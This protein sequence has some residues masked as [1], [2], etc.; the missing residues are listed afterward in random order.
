MTAQQ[1]G[2][3]ALIPSMLLLF[4]IFSDINTWRRFAKCLCVGAFITSLAMVIPSTGIFAHLVRAFDFGPDGTSFVYGFHLDQEA[5]RSVVLWAGG[6][7]PILGFLL[8]VASLGMW[9]LMDEYRHLPQTPERGTR[10]RKATTVIHA[11]D[12][13]PPVR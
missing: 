10:L 11:S 5:T 8:A 12:F 9:I 7:I 1:I 3:F 6:W 2:Y 13:L 4:A